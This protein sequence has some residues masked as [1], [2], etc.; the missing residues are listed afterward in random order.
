MFP[1][2]FLA[3]FL[4]SWLLSSA[5][6]ADKPVAPGA[7][8]TD[9]PLVTSGIRELMQDAKYAEAVAAIDVEAKRANVPADYLGYLKG[10]ALYLDKKYDEAVAAFQQVEAQ[11]PQS[12]WLRRARFGE[13]LSH[14]RKGDFA[15]AEAIYRKQAEYLLSADRK[16]QI[17]DI[18]LQFA[19]DYF[20][21]PGLVSQ[22]GKPRGDRP[23]APP[24]VPGATDPTASAPTAD[25]FAASA[26]AAHADVK[27]PE[28]QP[29]YEKALVFYTKALE[30]GPKPDEQERIELQIARCHQQLGR[31]DDAARLDRAF[32]DAHKKSP[33]S[34]EVRFRLGEVEL[35]KGQHAEARRTWQDLLAE[36]VDSSSARIAEAMFLLSRTWQIPQP[37]DDRQLSLG[38]AALEGFL[39]RFPGD[40]KAAGAHLDIARS[41]I[42]R[43]R[44]EE[45]VASLKAFLALDRYGQRV[46]VAEARNLLGRC[47]QLQ[48]KFPEA[49]ATWQEYLVKH[50]A[51]EAWSA[52]QREIINT[53]FLMASD[54]RQGKKYEEAQKL[55]TAFL[56]KY[57]LDARNPG[58][59]YTF[60]EMNHDEEKW[61][62]AIADWRR[63]VSKYPKSDE[64][65]RGQ[66]MIAAT[67]EE[68]LGRLAESLEEYKKLDWGPMVAQAQQAIARLTA[69]SLTVATERIFRSD[70]KPLVK[71]TSRNI[72][73]VTVRAYKVDMETYFRKMHLATGV[74]KLDIALI[75]PDASFEF[76]IPGYAE[77]QQTTSTVEVPLP[78]NAT[79][80]VMAVTVS[81]K[82]LEATTLVIQS[83]LDIV[84]KSSR[85]EV[86]V[87][88][89]NMLTG[90]PWPGAR[91]LVSNAAQVFAEAATGEDGVFHKAFKELRD[92]GDVRVFAASAGHV[93]SNVVGLQGVGVAQGLTDRGYI[94]T[95]RPAYRA[96]DLVHVRG[97]LRRVAD[98]RYIVPEGKKVTLQAFDPRNRLL[99]EE[100]ST[101][102]KFG[103]FHTHFILPETSPQ[104]EYRIL[105]SDAEEHQ[106]QGGFLVEE[107]KL[108]PVRLVVDTPRHVYYRG[109][110]IEGKIRA[111]FYHGAP[112]AGRQVTYQLAG[113]RSYTATTDEKGEVKFE[114]STR[115]F[116]ESQV[117][118][119]TVALPERSIARAVN[120]FLATQGFSISLKTVRP[121]YVAGES[122]EVALRT[123]DAEGKPVAG[124]LALRVLRRTEV[125]GKVG[126]RLVE[127][128]P[129]ETDK[130]GNARQTLSLKE[131]GQY[132]CR[133]VGTDRFDN[134]VSGEHAVT[135]SGEEDRVR[136]RIL[137]D[138]HTFKVG[139]TAKVQLLWREAPALAL[140]THQGAKI[141]D[142][143]LVTLEKG[144]NS[145]EIPMAAELAPNFELA[146]AV[147][148][149]P[150]P[151]K[152]EKTPDLPIQRFHAASS[153]F[154]VER[155]LKV[156]LSWK[157]AGKGEGPVRPGEEIE[158][159]IKT[160][161][162][163]GKPVAAELSLGMVEKSLLDRFAS[164]LAPIQ[165]F[166]RGNPREP[167]VRTTSSITF[168]YKPTTR[169]INTRLLAESDRLAVEREEAASRS[170]L[171]G[172]R[173]EE[174]RRTAPGTPG[175]ALAPE[176]APAPTSA[177][178][179]APPRPSAVRQIPAGDMVLGIPVQGPYG[180]RAEVAGQPA[181]AAG[182]ERQAGQAGADFDQSGLAYFG[183]AA[184]YGVSQERFTRVAGQ[185]AA[186][187]AGGEI[188]ADR[189][190]RY[191]P[192][193][194][195]NLIQLGRQNRQQVTILLADGQVKGV[196]LWDAGGFDP[197]R[198]QSL[199]ERLAE[200]GAVLLPGLGSEETGFWDPAVVTGEE[201]TARVTFTVPERST[202]WTIAAKGISVE[203]L[204]GE[205]TSELTVKKDLFGELKLPA[206]FTDGDN[207]E[208]LATIHNGQM[209]KGRIR[210]TLKT[211]IAG[212]TVSETKTID[213]AAKGL[214]ETTFSCDLRRPEGE[215]IRGAVPPQVDVEFELTVAV[216]AEGAAAGPAADVVRQAVPLK[217]YG[218][219][220]F[221]TASGTATSDMTAWVEPPKDMA[222]A[223]PSLQI[224]VGPTVERS[225][226]DIVLAPAPRC[227][228]ETSRL[229]S[230]MESTTS[231]LMAL[232]GLQELLSASRAQGTPD[233]QAIDQRIRGAT[234]AL[235]SSQNDDGGWSWT[236]R[237]GPS[238]RYASARAVWALALAGKAAYKVSKEAS[239]KATAYLQSQI[240]ATD[241]DDYE[242]KA[243]LLHALTVAGQE[244][245]TL[246]NRLHRSRPVLSPSAL[247]HTALAFAAMNRTGTAKELADAMAEKNLD[248][249]VYRRAAADGLLPWSSGPAELR[250]LYALVLVKVDPA[251]ERTRQVI[252]WL[253]AHRTGYRWTPDKATGPAAL[254]LCQWYAKS[255]YEGEKY[256]LTVSVNG[257]Q[258]A[259]LEIEPASL[260]Q[261]VDV[262]GAMLAEGK[263]RIE[264]RIAGRGRYA[265]QCILGGF[266][267]ADKLKNTTNLWEVRRNYDPAPLERDG[268]P[269]ARGFDVL[270]GGYST[271]HNPLTELPVARRGEVELNVWRNAL[272]GEVP[273]SQLEYLV[274]TEPIPCGCSVAADSVQGGFERFEISPGEITFYVGSRRHVGS[275]RYDLVGYLPG[276]YRAGP[277][278]VRNAYRPGEL[279]ASAAKSLAV[280]PLGA[281]S[282]DEYRL[283]PR[284]LFELG[285]LEFAAG[286]MEP[287][288]KHLEEL[289]AKWNLRP[290]IYKEAVTTLLDSYLATAVPERIV[291]YFEIVREKWPGE[292]IPF[293]KILKVGAAYDAMREFER[294]Y[295]V[296]RAT[297]ESSF[298]RESSVAGFLQS[299]GEFLR[300]VEV[301]GRLL[302]QYP[303][304]SYIAAADYALAQQVYAA[305]PKAAED[306]KLR[307]QKV[308]RVMLIRRAWQMLEGFLTAHPD[309]PAAD[310]AAFAAANTL[311]DIDAYDEAAAACR[312]YA[313]RYPKS[314]LLDAFWYVIG[315]C[316]FA[317]GKHEEALK[318]CR[319][320]AESKRIDERTG[321]QIESDDK[322]R[323][324]YI[325]GQIHHS[326]GQAAQ[327]IDQYRLVED[328]FP[329]AK[330]SIEYF[331]RKAIQLGEVTT[332]SPGKPVEIEL[333]YRNIAEC[334]VKVYRIDL[335][336][337]GLLKR[338]LKG[339][340][341]INLAGIQP[342][343]EATVK[344]GDGKDYRDCRKPL[345]LP[346]NDDG[347]YLVVC[348]GENLYASG[349]VLV[350]PL[351]VE[352][353]EDAVA[354]QVRT[355]VKD[356][357]ADRY[358]RDVHVKTIGSRNPD[359]VSGQTDLRGVFVA[360]GIMGASTVI[361][362]AGPAHYAFFRGKTDLVP[363][364]QTQDQPA[365][366]PQEAKAAAGVQTQPA[367]PASLKQ[368]LLEG[369]QG[370]NIIEQRKQ[371]EQLDSLYKAPAK[372]VEASKALQ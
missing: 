109:E 279:I 47:C 321:R 70:E 325:L 363:H 284:E 286:R 120:F 346:L 305:A 247:A 161:D 177:P 224:L 39:K 4:T 340:T 71:L 157:R 67:L 191:A 159:T 217:P 322:W 171:A 168:A 58:I 107:Y 336:K 14:A 114:L 361:A 26:P 111:E 350:T 360:D 24:S 277:T 282:K 101:L 329:D 51:H 272:A 131:G 320:V 155:D 222:I 133:A 370:R 285:K 186:G 80:G 226:V 332:V 100:E 185:L 352:V 227:Q 311:L 56:A 52:V 163:Q 28:R 221:A 304:E 253:M 65:S 106:Y 269:V 160:T 324:V 187:K 93:A 17:A 43:G 229:A 369:V 207:A 21:P 274:V 130:E 181:T 256:Q 55:Y 129:M 312:R 116:L 223:G 246:A 259:V 341:Q 326:L 357:T 68:K 193:N 323:A 143:R 364:V 138:R 94:Y 268:K 25:P 104:G 8:A 73:S 125:D 188:D 235:V 151:K 10:R 164:S 29:D 215:Q 211:T 145:L 182:A 208:V 66:Y 278:V 22:A 200:S 134:V 368:Q 210:V 140:V 315:Y 342:Y 244:D 345:G 179:L 88:A 172:A 228:L 202:A 232:V 96:G 83:D 218:M 91:L 137:A 117:L 316:Q 110:K 178:A 196:N 318:M 236:G 257:K 197:A 261:T 175:Y 299:Q 294:S 260:T 302:R 156:E 328:R 234:S 266:V 115:D 139:D 95:D 50:P 242:S 81:S 230:G 87:F 113:E 287:A 262:P 126:E 231:D 298:S 276:A 275:I 273:D 176:A 333:E 251:A 57:P 288:Q 148:T 165:A 46:E 118:A 122:F 77:Y 250:A 31:L 173:A 64:A 40:E 347:A 249:A 243:I 174:L 84:V 290:E 271:F 32:L 180:G 6:G 90:K 38:V 371:V 330:Q 102:G 78:K 59:L 281:E 72:E 349:L 86:F 154:T 331:T 44:Y 27:G 356:R 219:P 33:L 144:A 192:A 152:G 319:K 317:M 327:A 23:G 241:A 233:L 170:E 314:D 213:V 225:L 296:F 119:L 92:A 63:L 239:D 13:A 309:D 292:N 291:R 54:A 69:K 297:I 209:E 167:A 264:F 76:A 301:M 7:T 123:L 338:D 344:L 2:R 359:F 337:F 307:E 135:I 198:A 97:C 79:A 205:T 74:E 355:T 19:D 203:T 334:D 372:G 254:A 20:D 136:L 169:P 75:D 313:D 105:V 362:Q 42:H 252:D 124:K 366:A 354:G 103:S 142:Y 108:E 258:A 348:R 166:F 201:G 41:Y 220:V 238:D 289:V 267:P 98:D 12:T 5:I 150:R 127:E 89:E 82:T 270:A 204:A 3:L 265:Y 37:Q 189:F 16:Q 300:S 121:V 48:K 184:G 11:F 153:P 308:N 61:D 216:E 245:F 351:V 99:R 248:G 15:K 141:L 53:E 18:Y 365:R 358:L 199:A 158:V 206:A 146:V 190:Y 85:D 240:A 303:P 255:R 128:H 132:V 62:A 237:G 212:R 214:H 30:V 112:L 310:Q 367:A 34:V 283:T 147:M 49:L 339:I 194:A 183:Q 335:M 60:G 1:A 45:A 36:H 343:H 195:D 280:L 295:L 353:Q 263:Q 35:A 9:A 306:P 293:E 162:P 149:D